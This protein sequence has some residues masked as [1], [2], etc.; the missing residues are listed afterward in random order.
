MINGSLPLQKGIVYGPVKS[1]RFGNSLGI[2]LSPDEI[3]MCSLNCSYCQYSWTGLLVRDAAPFIHLLPAPEVVKKEVRS[4]LESASDK[5]TV[6]DHITFSGNGEPTLHPGFPEIVDAVLELRGSL[7]PRARVA[8]LS[9]SATLNDDNIC[10]AL[11][12]IDEA[13]M[14]LDTGSE[15]IFRKLNR[16]AKEILFADILDGLAGLNGRLTIQSLFVRG[17]VDNTTEEALAAYLA[18]LLK[19]RPKTVQIYTLDRVPADKKLLS[20][21]KERLEEIKRMIE[22]EANLPAVVY[23]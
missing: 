14:K 2:N 5:G 18:A 22:K 6:I 12:K 10:R 21:S 20:V 15:E 8:C 4:A 16:P 1:R 9:N 11:L 19:I 17:I 3:K 23:V 7:A 13:V